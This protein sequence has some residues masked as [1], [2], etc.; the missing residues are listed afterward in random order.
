MKIIFLSLIS[1]LLAF[2][3]VAQETAQEPAQDMIADILT[4]DETVVQAVR[5]EG[6]NVWIKLV[7]AYLADSITV[8][9]SNN[10]Q[11]SYRN[12]FNN[13]QDLVSDG[14]R[15]ANAWSDRVQT[16]AKYIEYWHNNVLV[17]HLKRR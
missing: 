10:N 6:D 11:D 16:K 5:T 3:V 13:E 14:L 17:L 8:R 15:G 2:P 7:P 4:Q 9:I 1:F 12:W